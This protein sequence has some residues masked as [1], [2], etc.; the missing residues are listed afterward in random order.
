MSA[1]QIRADGENLTPE[2]LAITVRRFRQVGGAYEALA[3]RIET[4]HP[5]LVPS[6]AER[7]EA[8]APFVEESRRPPRREEDVRSSGW[9][10]A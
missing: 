8:I 6:P 4:D 10:G 7:M 1:E 9:A 5:H 2:D 3:S